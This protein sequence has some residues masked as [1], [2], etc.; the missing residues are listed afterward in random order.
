MLTRQAAG[1]LSEVYVR[2]VGTGESLRV[3]ATVAPQAVQASLEPAPPDAVP[4]DLAIKPLDPYEDRLAFVRMAGRAPRPAA[5]DALA[6]LVIQDHDMLVRSSAAN[7]LGRLGSEQAGEALT[8]A[9][10]DPDRRV[11]RSVARALG[12]LGGGRGIEALGRVPLEKRSATVRRMAAFALGR[13]G[14]DAALAAREPAQI[15]R[16]RTVR[17][18]AETALTRGLE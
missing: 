5:L 13:I 14:N 11:R 4:D 12:S 10:A 17:T 8:A 7:A 1:R 15:D 16:D 18:L 3:S 6:A 2:L 9:L